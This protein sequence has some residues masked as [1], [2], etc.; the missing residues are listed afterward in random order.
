[1]SSNTGVRSHHGLAL[2]CKCP[3]VKDVK[4]GD[5][6]IEFIVATFDKPYKFQLIVIYA[7]PSCSLSKLTRFI[8]QSIMN[9]I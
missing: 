6:S 7:Q 9:Q 8:D 5:N 1:M 3:P 2:Y 4:Q